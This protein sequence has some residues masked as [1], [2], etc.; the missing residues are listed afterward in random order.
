MSGREI[1]ILVVAGLALVAC[2]GSSAGEPAEPAPVES[3]EQEDAGQDLAGVD[4]DEVK[5]YAL[6]NAAQMKTGTEE[7]VTAADAYYALVEANDFDYDAA[8]GAESEA[9]TRLVE[10]ARQSWMDASL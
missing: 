5:R 10:D 2:G 4:L 7:L 8:W 6:G 3:A 1:I 9:L